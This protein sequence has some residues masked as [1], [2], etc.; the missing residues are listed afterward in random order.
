MSNRRKRNRNK[1]NRILIAVMAM[2]I[3]VIAMSL[4]L[5]KR[6]APSTEH[7]EL[8]E[9]FVQTEADEGSVILNGEYLAPNEGEAVYA[10]HNEDGDYLL[11]SFVKNFLDDGYTY[12]STEKILRYTT[13]KDVITVNYGDTS[14]YINKDERQLAEPVILTE[15]DKIYVSSEF[16]EALTDITYYTVDNPHRIVIETAGWEHDTA[17]IKRNSEIRRFGGNKS[18]ILSNVAKGDQVIIMENYGKWSLVLTSDGVL[19]CIK[20]SKMKDK[21]TIAT[22]ANLP[23]R[24]YN[25][26]TM[27]EKIVL[28]WHQVTN[29][30]ANANVAE[31]LSTAYGVNV[32]SPTWFYFNDN[33]GGIANLCSEDYVNYCHARGIQVWA[34]VS[35]LENRNVDTATGLNTTS[36]RDA[37]VNNLIAAAIT[38]NLDGINVDIEALPSAAADGYIE[39]IREL[40]LKCEKNDLVL[41]VD[42]YPPSA[43]TMLYD[44]AEQSKYADYIVIMGYDEHYGGDEEAGSVASI[45]FVEDAVSN[46]M[47][48]VPA[49]QIVLGMPFYSRVWIQNNNGTLTSRVLSIENS[50]KYIA[51][52]GFDMK[53]DDEVGQY[54]GEKVDGEKTF[55]LWLEDTNSLSKKLQVMQD[56][57]LAGAAFWKLGLEDA[58]AWSTIVTF[59]GK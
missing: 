8:S 59:F 49:E 21:E 20:N 26:I 32:I 28:G 3:A 7:M 14:Y 27:D 52:N 41:S 19:G 51:E 10:I 50:A 42:N 23:E 33:M 15:Y 54:Y 16:V 38:Y 53:W 40:S 57:G 46:T 44:R 4:I 11:L 31:V 17:H 13:D 43:N 18:K 39:F 34:L 45:G 25:H 35:N 55:M 2:F 5:L 1:N 6:Y 47:E 12:D 58:N 29:K 22:A 30:T 48:E 37:L 36:A 9:Y 56:S 24:V